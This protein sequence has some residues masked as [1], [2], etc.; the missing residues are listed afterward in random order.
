MLASPGSD[1]FFSTF[2]RPWPSRI[3]VVICGT[4][5]IERAAGAHSCRADPTVRTS[6]TVRLTL[7]EYADSALQF[8]KDERAAVHV[9]Y[10]GRSAAEWVQLYV[11]SC[12]IASQI[13][14]VGRP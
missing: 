3:A 11:Y 10:E 4:S 14:R 9:S 2:A 8:R 7:S 1:T 6:R 5:S 12:Y 13:R